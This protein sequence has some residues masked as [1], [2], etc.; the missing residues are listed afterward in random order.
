MQDMAKL[1]I[2][3]A[4]GVAN[5]A[6]EKTAYIFVNADGSDH[7]VT[8]QDLFENTNRMARAL[9]KAGIGK[10]DCFVLLM[11]NHPEFLYALFGALSLG[12]VAVPIDPRSKGEKLAFQINNTQSRGILVSSDF[13]ENLKEIKADIP[14]VPVVGVAGKNLDKTEA[15]QDYPLL[16][17]VMEAQSADLPDGLL[18]LDP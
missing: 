11:R 13:L 3:Q 14:G 6:P 15:S 2:Y 18:P 8:N 4:V 7:V 10:G 9:Q 1:P 17:Q 16:S 12:A 5:P